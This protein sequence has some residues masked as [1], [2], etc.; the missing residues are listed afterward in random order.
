M[1]DEINPRP[2]SKISLRA[3][4]VLA[5]LGGFALG[6]GTGKLLAGARPDDTLMFGIDMGVMVVFTIWFLAMAL[7][8]S[9]QTN[10]NRSANDHSNVHASSMRR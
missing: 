10:N 3:A 9:R 8:K 7:R 4:I 2:E 6:L 5:V 1:F